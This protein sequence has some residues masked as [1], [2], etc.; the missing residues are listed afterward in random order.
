MSTEDV[1]RRRA[2]LIAARPRTLPAGAAPVAVGAGVALQEG[3][4]APLPALAALVG[5]LL[6]QVGTNLANDYYDA[7]KGVDSENSPG[8]TRVTQAGLIEPERVKAAMW[9][10]F[11]AA[12]GVG[13][14]LAYA[15][16]FPIVLVGLL[17]IASGVA[18]AGGPYPLG[19][20]GLGDL[21]VFVWFGVV[22]VVG[23]YYAQAVA[24]AGV[25]P[26]PLA[27]PPGTIPPIALVASLPAAALSTNILVVNNVRDLEDD[28]A[29]GK[30]TLA[31]LVG[32]RWSRV[33]FLAMLGIADLAPVA[34]WLWFGFG[35]AV[36]LPLLTLPLAATVARTV[37]AE[38]SEAALN[39]ALER[40]GQLLAAHSL[41][42][43]VG[44]AL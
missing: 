17:G 43:A 19:S 34:L 9:G 36:L 23:T 12:I 41:L 5:A 25:G 16:G 11:A 8:Y 28:R 33:E 24:V 37:L 39:P 22:A 4:F 44:L 35:P 14:Y 2:W 26:L 38:T 7:E 3:V 40:T 29:A 1:S 20:H 42:L 27:P 32:Y 6:I 31:V 15:G 18:Y 21:L 30:Y 13:F 10:T